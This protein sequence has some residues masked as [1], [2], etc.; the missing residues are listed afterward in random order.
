MKLLLTSE[1]LAN[2]K[3][4][5][6]FFELVGKPP[7]KIHI[8]YIPTA[9]NAAR[10]PHKKWLINTLVKFNDLKIGTVDI[11]DI[12][13][14]PEDMWL[15]RLKKADVIYV[16]GGNIY[17]LNYWFKKSDLNKRIKALLKGKVYVGASAGSMIMG[18]KLLTRPYVKYSKNAPKTGDTNGL[19]LV[20]FSIRPHFN[21]GDR[22]EFTKET[23]LKLAKKN[24]T[25]L[26]ALDDESAILINGKKINVISEGNW[27]IFNDSKN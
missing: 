10:T 11:V 18:K 7:K 12:S 5:K 14:I 8:A 1:G 2:K 6:T 25:I 20:K 26:Y 15:P 13:A 21:R 3:I 17:F 9:V 22:S 16:E 27:R 24:K 23:L 4:E 19:G